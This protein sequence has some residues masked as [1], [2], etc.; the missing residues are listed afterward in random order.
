M[1]KKIILVIALMLGLENN[2]KKLYKYLALSFNSSKRCWFITL[3]NKNERTIDADAQ[4]FHDLTIF[5]LTVILY[6]PVKHAR[7]RLKIGFIDPF[8][9][10]NNET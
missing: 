8:G 5:F 1:R 7:E 10:L 4:Y 9:V 3:K 2:K 6:S